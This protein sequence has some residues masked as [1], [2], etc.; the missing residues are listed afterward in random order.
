VPDDVIA[1]TDPDLLEKGS[2][3]IGSHVAPP[4]DQQVADARDAAL[5]LIP[6]QFP[7][8]FQMRCGAGRRKQRTEGRMAIEPP[9][10]GEGFRIK[11]AP[12]Q[13]ARLKATQD[14]KVQ[15]DFA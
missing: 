4:A 6:D 11:Q 15:L 3:A 7:D 1:D 14:L 2:Q 9:R 8:G 12:F 5:G 10:R 13:V